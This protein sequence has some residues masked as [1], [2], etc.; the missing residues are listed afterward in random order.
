MKNSKGASMGSGVTQTKRSTTKA[1]VGGGAKGG[2]KGMSTYNGGVTSSGL[3]VVTV[4]NR[5]PKAL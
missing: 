2:G 3:A 4:R 5:M 1:L